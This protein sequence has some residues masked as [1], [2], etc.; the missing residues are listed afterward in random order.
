MPTL[1]SLPEDLVV[2]VM[3]QMIN[4]S[5]YVR[6]I[7]NWRMRL[8]SHQITTS[9]RKARC[10][11]YYQKRRCLFYDDD[12][13]SLLQLQHVACEDFIYEEPYTETFLSDPMQYIITYS[14]DENANLL[15]KECKLDDLW[16]Y[17]NS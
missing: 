10:L 6:P 4:S 8:T 2:Y 17:L 7:D 11:V 9:F 16:Q 14:Y 12:F 3:I 1:L 13:R 5:P 15:S